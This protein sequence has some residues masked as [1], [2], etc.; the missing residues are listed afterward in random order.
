MFYIA[1]K[2][3]EDR[4]KVVTYGRIVYMTNEEYERWEATMAW[5]K[6]INL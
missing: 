1:S 5:S 3:S 6:E 4:V 2:V